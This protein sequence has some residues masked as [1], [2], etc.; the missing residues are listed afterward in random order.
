V[1]ING[2]TELFLTKVDVLTGLDEIL[3]CTGYQRAGSAIRKA[4]FSAEA[5]FLEQCTPIYEPV[6]GW[7]KDLRPLRK[8]EELPD[9]A[10]A[11]IKFIEESCGIPVTHISVGPERSAVIV[12]E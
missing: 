8:W 10:A 2:A 7:Q 6:P 3:V 1:E 9:Q 12:R 5:G 11:Y 4:D